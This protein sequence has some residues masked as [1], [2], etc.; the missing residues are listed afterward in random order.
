MHETQNRS[1]YG[2]YWQLRLHCVRNPC[3]LSN[4]KG[5]RTVL[6]AAPFSAKYQYKIRGANH[7]FL[8]DI[9]QTMVALF[10]EYHRT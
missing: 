4:R 10:Q 8:L 2:I 7:I 1:I 5:A 3:I 6:P 9:K